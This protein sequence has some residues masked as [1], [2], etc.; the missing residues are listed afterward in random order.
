[1]LGRLFGAPLMEGEYEGMDD[2]QSV[3]EGFGEGW[4]SLGKDEGHVD[5]RPGR[6]GLLLGNDDGWLLKDG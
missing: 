4:P 5:G 1:M 2:G 6:L 3:I